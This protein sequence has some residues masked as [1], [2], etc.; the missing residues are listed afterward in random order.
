M[1]PL[2]CAAKFAFVS[3]NTDLHALRGLDEGDD[4]GL[5]RAARQ[6]LLLQD[7][8]LSA[9]GDEVGAGLQQCS[10]AAAGRGG[11]EPHG[12]TADVYGLARSAVLARRCDQ[13]PALLY[14]LRMIKGGGN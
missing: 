1:A 12:L 8:L 3:G 11:G 9:G 7:D 4:L 14:N 6:A 10:R 2:R 13:I 5:A